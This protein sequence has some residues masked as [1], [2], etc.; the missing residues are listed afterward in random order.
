MARVTTSRRRPLGEF[1]LIARMARALPLRGEGVVLPVGDDCAVVAPPRGEE[2]CLTV[3]EVVEDVHFDRRF[4]PHDIGWK[5]LAVNL[6]DLAAMGARPLWVLAVARGE[7]PDRIL[8]VARGIA[9]CARRYGAG[10]VGGNVARAPA[11]SVAIT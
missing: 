5:A 3:D 10:V 8:G 11:L 9:A 2:L 1:E 4:T 6:S 7:P